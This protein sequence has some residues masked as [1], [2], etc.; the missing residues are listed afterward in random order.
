MHSLREAALRQQAQGQLLIRR[1]VNCIDGR[2]VVWR[3]EDRGWSGKRKRSREATATLHER[4]QCPRLD[5]SGHGAA[6]WDTNGPKPSE[7]KPSEP[8]FCCEVCP[9]GQHFLTRE[10]DTRCLRFGCDRRTHRCTRCP[11]WRCADDACFGAAWDDSSALFDMWNRCAGATRSRILDPVVT[12]EKPY[13]YSFYDNEEVPWGVADGSI[14]WA[15][16]GP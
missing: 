16:G 5:D 7:P 9:P 4:R 3:S 12:E 14:H 1:T 13:I 10:V 8:V 15:G 11:W 6:R 2:V